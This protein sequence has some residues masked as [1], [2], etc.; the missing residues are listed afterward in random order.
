MNRSSRAFAA[1]LLAA[2][3]A[4]MSVSATAIAASAVHYTHESYQE[5]Q[6]QLAARRIGAVKFNKK[7][8]TVHV[9]LLDGRHMLASYPSHDEPQIAAQLQAKGVP[10]TIERHS[11]KTTTAHHRLRYIAGGILIVAIL[12]VLGV[13]LAGRRRNL[14]QTGGEGAQA[15]DA[16]GSG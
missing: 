13:L 10:Y 9:T 7:A 12:V 1:A 4:S 8:H 15:G 14:A 6:Q 11:A 16:S 3:V 2:Y 5:F